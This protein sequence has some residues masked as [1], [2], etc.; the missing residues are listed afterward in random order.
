M[1]KKRI[2]CM[3]G[4]MLLL[5]LCGCGQT[6]LMDLP[7]E[8]SFSESVFAETETSAGDLSVEAVENSISGQL[9]AGT[10]LASQLN[11]LLLEFS[12]G[13]VAE[14]AKLS[15]E[16]EAEE[17]WELQGT[18]YLSG[19]NGYNEETLRQFYGE[20]YEK[21]LVRLELQ[22]DGTGEFC[23]NTSTI[24][25]EYVVRDKIIQFRSLK[26]GLLQG[27]CGDGNIT[28]SDDTGNAYVFSIFHNK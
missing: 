11:G 25:V 9:P 13:H 19:Y 8:E 6:D 24:P 23:V 3:T 1:V 21:L 4:L 7:S 5:A 15:E 14:G 16:S 28:I 26:K 20:H 12:Q 18:Y 22:Q 2:L 17:F 10:E 27:V